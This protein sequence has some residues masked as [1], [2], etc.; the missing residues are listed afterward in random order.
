MCVEIAGA[1]ERLAT[2]VTDIRLDMLQSEKSTL[3]S[4]NSIAPPNV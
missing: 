2:D 1:I 4:K 3:K